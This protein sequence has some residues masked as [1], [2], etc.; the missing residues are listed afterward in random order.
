MTVGLML[1]ATPL[2][3]LFYEYGEFTAE[4]T[5]LTAP[6]LYYMALGMV[7]YGIQNVLFRAFYAK[8]RGKILFVSGFLSIT[9][10]FTLC[11]FLINRMGVAGLGLASAASLSVT[12]LV[13]VPAA[14]KM[15]GK[16]L[17]TGELVFALCKM[18]LAAF[19]MGVVVFFVR[20][21]LADALAGD[22]ILT[23]LM[24]AGIPAVLGVAVYMGLALLLQ[25]K[26]MKMI[27]EL[28]KSRGKTHDPKSLLKS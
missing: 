13:L 10:T 2:V 5:R 24:L 27:L 21:N 8:K 26:E 18:T 9:T 14:Y 20:E 4:S 22:S 12:S 16:S 28:V 17:I 7:G 3:R 11:S 6:A 15:L 23:R 25:L 1:L 19:M